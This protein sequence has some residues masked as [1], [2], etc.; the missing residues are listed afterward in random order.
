MRDIIGDDPVYE[1][2]AAPGGGRDASRVFIWDLHPES[3]DDC[4][5]KLASGKVVKVP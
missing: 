1:D 5:L 2:V 3:K 4:E